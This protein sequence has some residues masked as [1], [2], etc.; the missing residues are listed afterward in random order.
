M[1]LAAA[2]GSLTGPAE[3]VAA[4][5]LVEYLSQ[6]YE[7]ARAEFLERY[8]VDSAKLDAS[9]T[10]GRSPLGTAQNRVGGAARYRALAEQSRTLA[11]ARR[12]VQEI[13]DHASSPLAL[14]E[15]DAA[16]ARAGRADDGRLPRGGR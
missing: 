16:I 10:S 4:D 14:I 2:D 8:D 7:R 11:D 6:V 1:L 5:R 15:R 9:L 3:L 12:R 13:R